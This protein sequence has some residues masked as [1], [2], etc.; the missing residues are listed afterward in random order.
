M[1]SKNIFLKLLNKLIHEQPNAVHIEEIV[2]KNKWNNISYYLGKNITFFLITPANFAYCKC[3]FNLTTTKNEFEKKI[4]ERILFL[5]KNN[6]I[7]QLSIYLSKN[8]K[9][10]D[11]QLQERIF[12]ESIDFMKSFNIKP[13]KLFIIDGVYNS[14]SLFLAK[15]YKISELVDFNL[16]LINPFLRII[17]IFRLR[18]SFIQKIYESLKKKDFRAILYLILGEFKNVCEKTIHVEALVRDDVW[19]VLKRKVIGKGYTWFI[20]TP[21]NYDYCQ[22]YFNLKMNKAEFT[23]ILIKRFEYLKKKNED[24]QLHIHLGISHPYLN[25]ENQRK[26]F[27]ESIDFMKTL[28]LKPEK[29]VHG[30]L[31]YK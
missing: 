10:L 8:K 1:S 19:R 29:Y 14:H 16:F 17:N 4:R 26:K 31:I 24:I 30:R 9:F 28:T 11:N 2:N 12:K 27:E 18:L 3:V 15:Q 6:E 21:A 7:I 22:T 13:N 20:I 23:N 5:K 25:D